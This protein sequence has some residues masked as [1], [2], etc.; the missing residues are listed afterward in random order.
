MSTNRKLEIFNDI[1]FDKDNLWG[2][3]GA[4]MAG[5]TAQ[6]NEMSGL[7]IITLTGAFAL[8]GMK[9]YQAYLAIRNEKAKGSGK[10]QK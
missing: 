2:S 7:T 5:V 3:I 4:I 6:V 10:K 9:M 8:W 1:F